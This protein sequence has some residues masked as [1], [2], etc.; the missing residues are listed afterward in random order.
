MAYGQTGSGKTYTMLGCKDNPGIA[1]R[2]FKRLFKLADENSNR[3]VVTVSTYMLELYNDKLVD[4]LK[5]H[6][7]PEVSSLSNIY[8]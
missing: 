8:L 6:H 4:L 5:N 3:H 7:S 1:P 2:A